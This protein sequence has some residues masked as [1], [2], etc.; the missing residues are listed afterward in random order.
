VA[1]I[2][3]LRLE[4]DFDEEAMMAIG[5]HL[6]FTPWHNAPDHE[7]VGSINEARRVAYE[8]ISHLRHELNRKRRREPQAHETVAAYL[9]S[10]DA[11]G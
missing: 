10:L 1:E 2:R 7:P 6:S 11:P 8:R 9:A 4:G 3:V 5:Q